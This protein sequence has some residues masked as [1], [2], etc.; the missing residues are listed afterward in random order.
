MEDCEAEAE[1][2]A[3]AIAVAAISSDEVVG[4]GLG[5][6][7]VSVSETTSFGGAEID[8]MTRGNKIFMASIVRSL[9][10]LSNTIHFFILFKIFI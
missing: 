4:S 8:G 2:A 3:S 10:L 7:P 5:S 6:C 9:V 1:A